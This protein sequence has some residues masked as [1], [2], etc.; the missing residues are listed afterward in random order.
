[1][2]VAK[3]FSYTPDPANWFASCAHTHGAIFLDSARPTHPLLQGKW[4]DQTGRYSF[5][6]MNPV[7]VLSSKKGQIQWNGQTWLGNPF[8]HLQA[9]LQSFS[10]AHRMDLPP[11]QGGVAGFFSYDLLHHL[12]E[13]PA[14]ANDD[15][16]FPDLMLGV[17]GTV[18]AFD[19]EQ[20]Q[21]WII[22]SG[23][24]EITDEARFNRATFEI[25]QLEKQLCSLPQTITARALIEDV[26]SAFTQ[27]DYEAQIQTIIDYIVAGDIYQANMSRRWMC[28][29]PKT[30]DDWSLYQHLRAHNPAPFSAFLNF[31][32]IRILSSSPERF[33]SLLNR[34]VETRPI[35]GTR[36]SYPDHPEMDRR[37]L[38]DL[39]NN[40]KDRSENMMI[41]DLLRN[42]LSRVCEPHSVHTPKIL[43]IETYATVHHLV[44][45]VTGTLEPAYDAVDLIKATF[46]GGSITGA[47]K[48]RAMEILAELEPHTRGPY[49]G[50]I[51]YIGF[52]QAMDLNIIIRTFCINH[53]TL[54]FQTGGGIVSDS[55]PNDEYQETE[56][57]AAALLHVLTRG[58]HAI[59]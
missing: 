7:Q 17:Y 21:A 24:P 50:S 25:A 37:M 8:D 20:K 35:K 23:Y 34:Q 19:H 16:A 45:V 26:Q 58:V 41:V 13:V 32:P 59:S 4:P 31:D 14:H 28:E 15:C 12:E 55:R 42:D 6:A 40:L 48:I 54:T 3:P 22:G 51:G 49:C 1:V 29:L 44:S 56:A 27:H 36:K 10:C 2:T 11:W 57:K 47:P 39:Q 18:V 52:S 43:H 5:F 38:N 30:H 9:I 46:P 33:L 53:N